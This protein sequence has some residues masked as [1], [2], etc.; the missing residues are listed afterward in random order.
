MTE[1]EKI[2]Y[3]KSF[4]DKLATGI[5]PTDNSSVP[6]C[7]VAAKSRIVGCF[8]FVSDILG[9]LVDHPDTVTDLY[10]VAEWSVT[11]EML[12]AIECSSNYVSVRVFAQRIDA[13]LSAE[14]K[15]TAHHI[16][17]WLL[18]NGYLERVVDVQ[19]KSHTR[20]T[21]KGIDNGFLI[22]QRVAQTGKVTM[23]IRLNYFAQCCIRDH[24]GEIVAASQRPVL[25]PPL[26]QSAPFHIT[27][28]Q[29]AGYVPS[30]KPMLITQ[31]A[32]MISCLQDDA[33]AKLKP[34]DLTDWLM[35]L[36]LLQNTNVNGK[37]YKLPTEAGMALGI[38]RE[39]RHS[40]NGDYSVA[41][42]NADAQ[43][44]IVDNLSAVATVE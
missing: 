32:Y 29:L 27:F 36:G 17:P 8:S 15:F 21:Q 4:I 13:L 34:T 44:F 38:S 16:N 12:A 30:Q 40:Q 11:P 35:R 2:A 9:R 14:Q 7:D 41:L 24:L 28:A 10:R 26:R 25:E 5:D 18:A 1:L 6:E 19:G 22:E 23:G 42:Y 37:N 20:P 33:T 39:D 31:V 43:R 3:A